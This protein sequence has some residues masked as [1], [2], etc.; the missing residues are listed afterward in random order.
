[1]TTRNVLWDPA[2]W[3]EAEEAFDYYAERS[4]RAAEGFRT[5]L[6]E[7]VESIGKNGEAFP[8]FDHGA[9]RCLLYKYPFGVLF[10][11]NEDTAVIVVV[12]HTHRRPGYYKG[13]L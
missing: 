10:T 13:R 9:R 2:A 3:A 11:L 12:M 7:V 6:D 1:M 4:R 5:R 8:I